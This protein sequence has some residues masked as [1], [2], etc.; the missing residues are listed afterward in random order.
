MIGFFDYF[1]RGEE[2][3]HFTYLSLQ[4]TSPTN[5][6]TAMSIWGQYK[7]TGQ[8]FY[9]GKKINIDA[10]VYLADRQLYKQMK[11]LPF[12][13][14]L[15]KN[16]EAPESYKRN[17]SNAISSHNIKSAIVNPGFVTMGN[18]EDESSTFEL[19][20]DVVF[21]K[22]GVLSFGLPLSTILDAFHVSTQAQAINIGPSSVGDQ[23]E[24]NR[25]ILLLAWVATALALLTFRST[26]TDGR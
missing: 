16:A 1:H 20:G 5:V 14:Q 26:L 12:P 13:V 25:R 9:V 2:I 4:E 22:E 15:I 23:I 19:S 21:T 24:S 6:T 3:S 8:G 17:I 11:G 18:F 10:L 7:T